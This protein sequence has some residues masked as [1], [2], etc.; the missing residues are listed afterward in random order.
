MLPGNVS[1]KTLSLSTTLA[2][3]ELDETSQKR[4]YTLI[5]SLNFYTLV[6]RT[7]L[8]LLVWRPAEIMIVAPEECIY[9]HTLEAAA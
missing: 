6:Q 8:D 3:L 7:P 4:G 5:W 1:R 9:L 2:L